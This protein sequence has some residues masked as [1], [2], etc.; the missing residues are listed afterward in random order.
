M[1]CLVIPFGT[2]YGDLIRHEPLLRGIHEKYGDAQ[3]CFYAPNA[4]ILKNIPFVTPINILNFRFDLIVNLDPDFDFGFL[5][6]KRSQWGEIIGIT[7]PG[8]A[9]NQQAYN[10]FNQNRD[11]DKGLDDLYKFR[12]SHGK[13]LAYWLCDICNLSPKD[14]FSTHYY[15]TEDELGEAFA[16]TQNMAKPLVIMQVKTRGRLGYPF[17]NRGDMKNW[18]IDRFKQFIEQNPEYQFIVVCSEAERPE[19]MQLESDHCMIY[20]RGLRQNLALL[21]TADF[22]VGLD[23]VVSHVAFSVDTPSLVLYCGIFK[24]ACYPIQ[25]AVRHILYSKAVDNVLEITVEDVQTQFKQLVSSN[26]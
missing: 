23:S 15:P 7:N 5:Y 12:E 10:L 17:Q 13:N 18:P 4:D 16:V 9:T 26:T 22:F 25:P 24:H 20:A 6:Q 3:I 1:K 8:Q 14:G 21:Y 11:F 2:G 19:I